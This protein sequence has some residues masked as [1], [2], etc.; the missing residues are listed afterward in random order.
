MAGARSTPVASASGRRRKISSSSRP[1]PQPRSRRRSGEAETLFACISTSSAILAYLPAAL[2]V[3]Q[4]M[5]V[6]PGNARC[7]NA[8]IGSSGVA[9][10]ASDAAGAF[11]EAGAAAA[12]DCSGPGTARPDAG[13][14][15]SCADTVC[16]LL[17]RS[18]PDYITGR[19]CT[20]A[21]RRDGCKT[22]PLTKH[23]FCGILIQEVTDINSK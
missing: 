5:R 21:P 14:E 20:Q 4:H 1:V 8:D 9:A 6:V 3:L 13:T 11:E 15:F 22:N 16:I 10:G 2:D 12:A 18:P 7:E 17:M 23:S 19:R